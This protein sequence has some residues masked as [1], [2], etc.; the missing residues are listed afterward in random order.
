MKDL[1]RFVDRNIAPLLLLCFC[2]IMAAF[3][4]V[5]TNSFFSVKNAVNILE[6]NSYRMLIAVGMMC[7]IS[8]GA[9][10]LSVGSM[11]SFSAICMAKALK[12]ELP[13]GLCV[14]V[15]LLWASPWV[16]SMVSSCMLPA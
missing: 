7:I 12:A 13:V 9:I 11:L 14:G 1:K 6:A 2:G 8:S 3:L 15:A 5:R 16:R 10:D 4:S